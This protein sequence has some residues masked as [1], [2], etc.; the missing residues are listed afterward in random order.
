MMKKILPLFLLTL[1]VASCELMEMDEQEDIVPTEMA[2][3]RDTLYIMVGDHFSL[4]PVFSP[5]SVTVNDVLWTSSAAEVL[6]VGD[7]V[8]TGV[9]EGWAVVRAVSVSRHLEDSCYVNVM[10]RWESTVRDY[11]YEM[12]V[13]ADVDVHGHS[14]NPETMI[15]GAFVDDEMRG[16][17]EFMN[18]K[19]RQ[20][21]RI[22][23]GS[24]MPFYDPEGIEET[25]TFRVYNRQ[26]L[27]FESFPQSIRYDGEAHGTLSNL[28]KLKI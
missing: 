17:G 9:S 28:F 22:R 21:M 16:V 6:A 10:K 11:P 15:I 19:G 2:L 7:N 1:F 8:F 12:M 26:E 13:Y 23:V 5:D 3:E 14:F 27:R 24:E 4:Q 20:Y 18:W 25:V